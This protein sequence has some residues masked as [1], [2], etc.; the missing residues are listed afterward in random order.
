MH[1]NI[2][3][4]Q[5]VQFIPECI[6]DN[7][8]FLLLPFYSYSMHFCKFETYCTQTYSLIYQFTRLLISL[9]L[10]LILFYFHSH[11]LSHLNG[12][13]SI[14]NDIPSNRARL[15]GSPRS[16]VTDKDWRT[17]MFVSLWQKR[18]FFCNESQCKHEINDINGTNSRNKQSLTHPVLRFQCNR[19]HVVHC[20]TTGAGQPATNI[21]Y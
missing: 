15:L 13:H 9:F 21:Q 19:G 4:Y 5:W 17:F 10:L 6:P 11:L 8:Q 7:M 16:E 3:S 12:V 14:P 2:Q 1:A 20:W 18:H